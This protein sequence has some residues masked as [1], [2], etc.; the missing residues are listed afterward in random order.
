MRSLPAG[1]FQTL[2]KPL[3][4]PPGA[5][6]SASTEEATRHGRNLG[7]GQAYAEFSLI[8]HLPVCLTSRPIKKLDAICAALGT[9][10]AEFVALWVGQDVPV[11]VSLADV[12]LP[13]A[14]D[15]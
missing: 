9:A 6:S 15:E 1:A 13:C 7:S 12:D 4:S 5:L 8:W 2:A 3:A 10:Q 11:P 14:Q